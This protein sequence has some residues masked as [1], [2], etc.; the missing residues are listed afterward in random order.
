MDNLPSYRDTRVQIVQ[1]GRAESN[2]LVFLLV[3][4]LDVE[5]HQLL[6]ELLEGLGLLLDDNLVTLGPAL[7]QVLLAGLQ[8]FLG[9]GNL[10]LLRLDLALQILHGL[11]VRL[12]HG[13]L[14]VAKNG[15]RS[16]CPVV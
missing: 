2:L 8:L 6:L 4:R 1:L 11:L 10:L 13:A 16:V 3:R 12:G 15:Y 7:L 9:F 5:L 14:M